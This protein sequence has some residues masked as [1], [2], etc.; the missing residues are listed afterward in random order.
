MNTARRWKKRAAVDGVD[1]KIAL[2]DVRTL[3][4]ILSQASA[5]MAFTMV[6]LGLAAA[7]ALLLGVIGIYG[8]T[9]Y[10]VSQRTN[11][12]GLRLAL[13]AEPRQVTHAIVG[14]GGVVALAGIAI[15]LTSA[16]AGTRLIASLLY[17]VNPRDPATFAVTAGTLLVVAVAACWL[18]ARRAARLSPVDALRI[19]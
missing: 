8:V 14:Q 17:D 13:G 18:P 1:R 5:Q 11:E 9:A 4:T 7:V 6:L 2:S 10:I 12:I 19:E 3:E 16:L 15:G